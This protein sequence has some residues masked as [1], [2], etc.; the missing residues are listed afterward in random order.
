MM[1]WRIIT[2]IMTGRVSLDFRQS[3]HPLGTVTEVSVGRD[4]YRHVLPEFGAAGE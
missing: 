3:H 4:R 2:V 1:G